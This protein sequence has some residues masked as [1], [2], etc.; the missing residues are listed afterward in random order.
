MILFEKSFASHDRAKFI[1]EVDPRI[2]SKCSNKKYRFKCNNEDCMHV[3]EMRL[4]CISNGRWCS[5]CCIPPKLL[6]NNKHCKHCL[7]KSF[8]S[9]EKAKYILNI[10]PRIVFK[11]SGKKYKFKCDNNHQ[12]ESRLNQINLGHWCPICVN[13]TERK[14][15]D[16]ILTLYPDSIH[17]Y[18]VD[19][20]KNPKTDRHLPFDIYIGDINTIIEIDGLQHFQ[21]VDHFHRNDGDFDKRQATDLFK[22]TQCYINKVS[23]VRICQEYAFTSSRYEFDLIVAIEKIKERGPRYINIDPQDK[24]SL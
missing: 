8:A 16:F 13:K 23:L 7:N 21:Q 4:N 24:Y 12:F 20:C 19:W 17:Q 10:N 11:S 15:F 9:H 18:K 22:M 6:C 5:Y 1:L 2:L 3:F 14:V